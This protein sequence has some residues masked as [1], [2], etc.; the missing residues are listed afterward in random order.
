VL[1]APAKSRLSEFIALFSRL[2]KKQRSLCV[3]ILHT[4]A[5]VVAAT[6]A[7]LRIRIALLGRLSVQPRT[8]ASSFS[9]HVPCWSH[10]PSAFCP[11]AWPCSAACLYSRTA[12]ASSFSTPSPSA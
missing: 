5:H 3:V 4:L 6:E 1:V 10:V 7:V 11:P 9:T 2:P 8:L 12:F